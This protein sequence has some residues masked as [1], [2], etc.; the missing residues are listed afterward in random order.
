[1]LTMCGV[2]NYIYLITYLEIYL[3]SSIQW[4][5]AKTRL[6]PIFLAT[7]DIQILLKHLQNR[8]EVI[9]SDI[10]QQPVEI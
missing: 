5:V 1:M 7:F 8:K 3:S 4:Q 10:T 6:T 9:K 2:K